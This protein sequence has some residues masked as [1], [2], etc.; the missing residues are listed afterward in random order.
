MNVLF[1]QGTADVVNGQILLPQTDNLFPNRG[2]R[3]DAGLHVIDKEWTLRVVA[4]LM[5]Q[6][7]KAADR[8]S[9]PL[10][11]F[12]SRKLFDEIGPQGLVLTVGRILGREKGFG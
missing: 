4:K 5:S 11:D 7:V 10:G 2:A 8:V 1:L 3:L 6:L 12:G 9:K